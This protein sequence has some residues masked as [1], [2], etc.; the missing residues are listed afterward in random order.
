MRD[1]VDGHRAWRELSDQAASLSHQPAPT[2]IHFARFEQPFLRSLAAGRFRS[3]WS[4]HG[5][6]AG[7]YC[8]ICLAAA[9]VPFLDTSVARLARCVAAPIT[10]MRRRSSGKS[11]SGCSRCR[12]CRRGAR[13]TIG[14]PDRSSRPGVDAAFG[15]CRATCG[16]RCRMPLASIACCGQTIASYVG[17][18]ASLHHQVNS[19]FRKQNGVPERSLEMLSQARAISFDVTPSPLEAALLEPDEI[20][21]HRPPYNVAL[22]IQDRALWF[23]SP[24]LSARSSQPSPHCP[25]GPF[26]SPDTLDQFGTHSGRLRGADVRSMGPGCRHV[27]RRLR[28]AVRDA[29]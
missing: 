23:T 13:S 26:A 15:R 4:A 21:R 2:V 1:A 24:D 29:S 20:K 14:S 25:L 22:T 16:F 18:A 8:P 19:Y 17:K 6:L 3:T 28:A 10:W 9:C 7:A 12:V 5:T 27:Q 11:L